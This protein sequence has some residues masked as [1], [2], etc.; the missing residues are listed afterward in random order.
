[1]RYMESED[2]LYVNYVLLNHMNHIERVC[3]FLIMLQ[4]QIQHPRI[5]IIQQARLQSSEW[6]PINIIMAGAGPVGL[7][8]AI[9][10]YSQ[11]K[12]ISVST[13]NNFLM[14]RRGESGTV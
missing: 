5:K 1:M 7:I 11:G 10:A 6:M 8:T 14:F 3:S 9:E 4:L 2:E 13:T 12:G